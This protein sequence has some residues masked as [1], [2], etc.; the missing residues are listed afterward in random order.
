MDRGEERTLKKGGE[1]G[2]IQ[3]IYVFG[4]RDGW[5]SST[6]PSPWE[7]A[8]DRGERRPVSMIYRN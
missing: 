4:S 2:G 8:V 6:Q 1:V 5:A 3:G 7:G